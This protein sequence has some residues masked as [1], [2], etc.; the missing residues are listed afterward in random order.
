MGLS[1]ACRLHVSYAGVPHPQGVMFMPRQTLT[2]VPDAPA[3]PLAA[4]V[5]E[6]LIDVD[7]RTRNPRTRAFYEQ[8]LLKTLLPFAAAHGLRTPGELTTDL[9]NRLVVELQG[10]TGRHGRPL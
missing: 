8:G 1:W 3:S 5:E 4:A 10:R 9:L 6:Y 2:V 7:A